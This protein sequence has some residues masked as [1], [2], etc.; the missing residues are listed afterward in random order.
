MTSPSMSDTYEREIVKFRATKLRL[1]DHIPSVAE[2][3]G[4]D[5]WDGL[6]NPTS[7]IPGVFA[8]YARTESNLHNFCRFIAH[9]LHAEKFG[10]RDDIES[11]EAWKNAEM[12]AWAEAAAYVDGDDQHPV[13][14]RAPD[15]DAGISLAGIALMCRPAEDMLPLGTAAALKQIDRLA[16]QNDGRVVR[17]ALRTILQRAPDLAAE[18]A[19]LYALRRRDAGS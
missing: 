9:A 6:Q 16:R 10:R 3:W 18:V 8:G 7:E 19:H 14:Y 11:N 13:A 2:Q 1:I 5:E 12:T 15:E 17:T 4:D